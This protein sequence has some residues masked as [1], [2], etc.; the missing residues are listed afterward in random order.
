MCKELLQFNDKKRRDLIRMGKYL[1]RQFTKDDVE[2]ARE[3]VV[4]CS[5]Q[6][7][8]G[9]ESQKKITSIPMAAIKETD[10]M[11]SW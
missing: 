4:R 8:F 2:R 9:N 3:Y 11:E 1:N 5:S 6:G 10:E 7:V